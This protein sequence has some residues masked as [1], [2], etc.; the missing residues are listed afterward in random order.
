MNADGEFVLPPWLLALVLAETPEFDV[1][2]V[3]RKLRSGRVVEVGPMGDD[4]SRPVGIAFAHPDGTG[5]WVDVLYDKWEFPIR[6]AVT[7]LAQLVSRFRLLE[8]MHFAWTDV[9]LV[10]DAARALADDFEIE[11]H[12]AKSF[13]YISNVI[14]LGIVCMYA[15]AWTGNERLPDRWRPE[16]AEDRELHEQVL[17]LRN[18][19]FAHADRSPRRMLVNIHEDRPDLP[20]VFAE[21]RDPLRPDFL[22]RLADL[23]DRQYE[24]LWLETGRLKIEIGSAATVPPRPEWLEDAG[25]DGE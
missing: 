7:E 6:T 23:C 13:P 19:L 10:R 5:G 22:R 12:E 18:T 20:A 3:T 25:S 14:E 24:R 4:P 15:R 16:S 17:D 9:D 2:G 8:Q 11:D 1:D 21:A